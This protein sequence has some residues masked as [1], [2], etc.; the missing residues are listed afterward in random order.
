MKSIGF[1]SWHRS[2][3]ISLFL[4]ALLLAS[5]SG[6]GTDGSSSGGATPVDQETQST[7]ATIDACALV[8]KAEA[9]EALGATV[10]EP[11]RPAE[12]Q[13][14][15]QGGSWSCRYVTEN[16]T[17]V[18]VLVILVAVGPDADTMEAGYQSSKD[19][20]PEAQSVDGIGDDAFRIG[21]QLNVLSSN[22]YLNIG[23]D[24]ELE[25]LV[26]LAQKA[27]DRLP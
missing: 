23:G 11:E 10:G 5:C 21:N 22:L 12:A 24:A 2:V 4:G 16:V 18:A 3:M 15:E 7:G 13:F 17:P 9:E 20:F 14:G 1:P 27:L 8:T 25:V 26:S 6:S 19:Q